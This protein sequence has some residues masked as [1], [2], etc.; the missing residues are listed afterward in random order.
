MGLQDSVAALERLEKLLDLARAEVR[1]I[2]GK[3]DLATETST[4]NP[5]RK[6]IGKSAASPSPAPSTNGKH[7]SAEEIG[8]GVLKLLGERHEL[9][10]KDFARFLNLS[11]KESESA[12]RVAL[13][14]LRA[15]GLITMRG[16]RRA[17][18]WR[19]SA[20]AAVAL[21]ATPEA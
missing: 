5:A 19:L 6:R 8:K 4:D 12:L 3:S 17:A 15:K 1:A 2:L 10:K 20:A 9:A 13:E 16:Q 11:E 14:T 21:P 18:R 7:K